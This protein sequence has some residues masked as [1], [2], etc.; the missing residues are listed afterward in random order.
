MTLVWLDGR[1]KTR[2]ALLSARV[3]AE[4]AGFGGGAGGLPRV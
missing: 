1:D 2:T 3:S 4:G